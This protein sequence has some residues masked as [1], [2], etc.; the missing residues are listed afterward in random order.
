MHRLISIRWNSQYFN[1]ESSSEFRLKFFPESKFRY[2]K[3][4]LKTLWT[5]AESESQCHSLVFDI[6][7]ETPSTAFVLQSFSHLPYLRQ[8]NASPYCRN[9]CL[10]SIQQTKSRSASFIVSGNSNTRLLM[11]YFETKQRDLFRNVYGRT[12]SKTEQQ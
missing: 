9:I 5:K 1:T 10:A 6:V 8:H 4:K 12:I 3:K 2:L 11:A 7:L